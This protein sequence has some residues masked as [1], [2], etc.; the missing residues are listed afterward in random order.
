[1]PFRVPKSP[2]PAL[3][4]A[5]VEV[6]ALAAGAVLPVAVDGELLER[7]QADTPSATA[8]T[9]ADDV[10]QARTNPLW[11]RGQA[12]SVLLMK[13]FTSLRRRITPVVDHR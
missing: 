12:S 1:M 3:A 2:G 7:P 8:T 6:E 5:E 13:R 9:N 4:G 10:A 11:R